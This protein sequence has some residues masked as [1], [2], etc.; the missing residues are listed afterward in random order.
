MS[1]ERLKSDLVIKAQR[2]LKA[3]KELKEQP[4]IKEIFLA[5]PNCYMYYKEKE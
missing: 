2:Y 4:I 1:E 3:E 5:F